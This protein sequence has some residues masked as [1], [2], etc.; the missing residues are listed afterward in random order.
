MDSLCGSDAPV[1]SVLLYGSL[2][3]SASA[4]TSFIHLWSLK[5]D[6]SHKPTA[7]IPTGSAH[8]TITKDAD[9]VFYVRQQNQTEVRSWDC[10][11]G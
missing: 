7:H 3:V 4:A 1:T 9:C 8:V 10:S 2:V 6:T 11:T 5:Y